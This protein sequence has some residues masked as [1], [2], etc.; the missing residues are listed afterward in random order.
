MN[1]NMFLQDYP[2]FSDDP[3]FVLK[4]LDEKH[5]CEYIELVL[6]GSS[7]GDPSLSDAV[8]EYMWNRRINEDTVTYSILSPQT[9]EFMGYCQYKNLSTS[10]P[11]IG[12][13]ILPRFQHQG[14][15]YAVCRTLVSAFFEKTSRSELY[16]KV[17]R[18]NASSIALIE[19]LGGKCDRVDH[20]HERL[21]SI[22]NSLSAEEIAKQGRN[23][24]AF[25][26]ALERNSHELP[27]QEYPTDILIYRIG[28]DTYN[29]NTR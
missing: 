6:G 25:I 29:A 20:T 12:I 8:C 15:G 2:L 7:A 28:R 24:P 10:K 23:A 13:E 27:D 21:L 1:T 22:L 18:K 16:Y 17:E 19:K 5:K 9:L 4:L 3:M 26:A 11:D 14:I